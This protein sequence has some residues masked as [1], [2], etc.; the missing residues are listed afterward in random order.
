MALANFVH[1]ELH[2]LGIAF[3]GEAIQYAREVFQRRTLF[4]C[5]GTVAFR[6]LHEVVVIADGIADE[7]IE[8]PAMVEP[9]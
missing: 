3:V 4:L 6:R 1:F 9:W 5:R 7:P 8:A 2:L